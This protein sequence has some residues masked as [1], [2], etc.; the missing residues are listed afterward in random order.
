MITW[1]RA[2]PPWSAATRLK[3]TCPQARGLAVSGMPQSAPGM[4][5]PGKVTYEVLLFDASG[6]FTV[7]QRY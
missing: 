5:T 3:A 2:T 4:D 6:K 1:P 7:Y